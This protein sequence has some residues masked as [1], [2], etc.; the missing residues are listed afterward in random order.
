MVTRPRRVSSEAGTTFAGCYL[1][2]AFVRL[3]WRLDRQYVSADR[4]NAF[5]EVAGADMRRR[6]G[7]GSEAMQSVRRSD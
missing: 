3:L 6:R 7:N 1:C 5:G 2:R 4:A